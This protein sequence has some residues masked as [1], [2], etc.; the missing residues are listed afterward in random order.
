MDW[1]DVDPATG[2]DQSASPASVRGWEIMDGEKFDDLIKR[3]AAIRLTRAG[4]LRGLAAATAAALT[5]GVLADDETDATGKHH[6]S[7]HA[8]HKDGGHGAHKA[9]DKHHGKAKG[10]SDHHGKGKGKS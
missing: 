3:L 6:K 9:G 7:G 5:G 1:R 2:P 4:T 10:E 8:A